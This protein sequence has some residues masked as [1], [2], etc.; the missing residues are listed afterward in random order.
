MPLNPPV[1]RKELGIYSEIAIWS[2]NLQITPQTSEQCEK[3]LNR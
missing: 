3:M 1:S 2:I